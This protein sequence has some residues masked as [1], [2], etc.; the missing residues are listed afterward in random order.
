MSK[1][2]IISR[3]TLVEV[4]FKSKYKSFD[5][6]FKEII[7]FVA[8]Q[9]NCPTQS[10]TDLTLQ[11][12]NFKR[13][14]N[15][16]WLLH[17]KH[18]ERL[19]AN[20]KTWLDGSCKFTRFVVINSGRPTSNFSDSSENSKR[21]KTSSLRAEMDADF[22]TYAAQMKLRSSG[23]TTEAQVIKKMSVCPKY[24]KDC[25]DISTEIKVKKISPREAL[26]LLIEAQLSRKQYE[27][28]RNYAKDIFP[29]YKLVQ[30]EKALCYPKDV[31]VTET[32]AVVPLQ[33]LL[34]HTATRL[35]HS[36]K[37]VLL[38]QSISSSDKIVLHT[39]W[40]FDGSS[41]H[42]QYKQKFISETADDKYMFLSSLVPLRLSYEK[43]DSTVVLWQNP[44]PSSSRFCRPISLQYRKETDELVKAKKQDIDQ[45]VENL[46]PTKIKVNENVYEVVHKAIFTMVDGKLC[47]ALSDTKSTLKCYLCNATSKEFNNLNTVL[48]KPVKNDFISFGLSV[49]HC[50]IRLFEFFLHLSYKLPIQEWRVNKENKETVE[51]NKKRIQTEFRK[52]LSLIVDKPK[53]GFGNSN[54]GNVARIFFQN[55]EKSA[56]ITQIDSQLIKRFYIILQTISSGFKI[57]SHKFQ[58]F[59]HETASLY[60]SLYP[61]MPMTPTVH[62]LLI[63]G[64][65][66]VTQALLPIGQLSEEAQESR[67]KDFKTYRERFSRKTSRTENLIDIMNRLFISSDPILSLMRKVP[68]MKRKPFDPEVIEM[69]EEE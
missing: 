46:S 68:K 35:I 64:P 44:K 7:D 26:S 42:T 32:E 12:R 36:Q 39:K 60:V 23:R 62:K 43:N 21:R 66:I 40:G 33:S 41:S 56:A 49:L 59:C 57:N 48:Q 52:Q 69:L 51:Q 1:N 67:N 55:F 28:I 27:I 45:Q 11:L 65:E 30:A 2:V 38:T 50:W 31:Q 17:G 8:S 53:P 5:S 20:E 22:L 4:F 61:W 25:F 58:T 24:A 37:S 18:R 9:T 54:D 3:K 34:D 6:K 10:R 63:H 16:K 13:Q 29:S 14:F 19:F 47:N 15:T